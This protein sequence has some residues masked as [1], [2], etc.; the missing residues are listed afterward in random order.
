[1]EV[2][3]NS[4]HRVIHNVLLSCI[5]GLAFL[6]LSACGTDMLTYSQDAKHAGIG[7]YNDGRYAEAAGAFR[8]AVRQDPTDP[9][10]EYWLGLSYEQTGSYHESIIAYKTALDVMPEP[11]S[12]KFSQDLFNKTFDRLAYVI[13][14][15]DET[16]VETDLLASSAQSNSSAQDYWLL[17]RVFRYRGDADTS[18]DDYHRS[19]RL[20]P[21]NFP[22][23]KELGL[24]LEQ[25]GQIQEASA[26]LRDAWRLNP[27]DQDIDAA[28]RRVGMTPGPGLLQQT[29][30][31]NLPASSSVVDPNAAAPAAQN[32]P[33]ITDPTSPRD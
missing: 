11:T 15:K 20:N 2:A 23:Q 16:S 26:V 27:N 17:G 24:Y 3:V 14:T 10:A 21:E 25:L 7:L 1:M 6:S 8:N 32:E 12:A 30:V 4:S 19:I 18:L 29:T 33:P 22:C 31:K 13:A 9:E 5:A 28:L